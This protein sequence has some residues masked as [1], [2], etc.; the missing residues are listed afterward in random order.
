MPGVGDFR[1]DGWAGA[2]PPAEDFHRDRESF[3]QRRGGAQPVLG[4]PGVAAPGILKGYHRPAELGR[5]AEHRSC[6]GR[7]QPDLE[8]LAD[9]P[10]GC[11]KIAG[12]ET[13]DDT[14]AFVPAMGVVDEAFSLAQV[15]DQG[16][17]RVR[18]HGDVHECGG[19]LAEPGHADPRQP[20]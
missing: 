20:I 14:A 8:A 10:A 5:R 1:I 12:E 13:D 7:L 9:P 15:D 17:G 16:D 18:D 3:V 2:Q 19:T 11:S 6:R 4:A